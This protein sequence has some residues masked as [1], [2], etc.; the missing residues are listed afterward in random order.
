MLRLFAGL[1]SFYEFNV[2]KVFVGDGDETM[3]Q[4]AVSKAKGRMAAVKENENAD[5][6]DSATNDLVKL[7]LAAYERII[8][9]TFPCHL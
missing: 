8:T 2:T 3:D 6:I 7:L 1:E 5:N 9:R 4:A